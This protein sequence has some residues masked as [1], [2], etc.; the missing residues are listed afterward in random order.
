M[1]EPEKDLNVN[2]EELEEL[3]KAETAEAEPAEALQEETPKEDRHPKHDT[4]KKLEEKLASLEAEKEALDRKNAE[5]SDMFLRK[6]AEFDNYRKRT[7]REKM[8]SFSNGKANTLQAM[9]PVLDSL[10]LAASTQ[11]SDDNYKK[12]V[13]LTVSLM[14]VTLEKLGV[15]KIDALGKPFDPNFHNAIMTEPAG[16][17]QESGVVSKVFQNGY[18]LGDKCIRP[19][20]VAVTE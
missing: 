11:C 4:K 15:I 7:D 2:A 3:E 19:A 12:G 14:N 1:S 5:L 17:G 13:D 20:M 8:E 10:E 18:M 9:L 6:V 16:E